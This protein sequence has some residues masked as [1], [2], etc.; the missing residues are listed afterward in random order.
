LID[1]GSKAGTHAKA[2]FMTVKTD[3]SPRAIS[4]VKMND[5]DKTET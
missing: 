5:G 4:G 3:K 2:E 1:H